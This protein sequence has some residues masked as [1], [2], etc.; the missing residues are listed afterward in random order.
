[1]LVIPV[2]LAGLALGW[3]ASVV[4]ATRYYHGVVINLVIGPAGG[5]IAGQLFA[6]VF[7]RPPVF[8]GDVSLATLMISLTGA[9]L[10]LGIVEL[11]RRAGNR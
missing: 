2:V 3:A 6:P 11:V 1:M 9:A 4:F 7:N 8:S 10:M 5:L